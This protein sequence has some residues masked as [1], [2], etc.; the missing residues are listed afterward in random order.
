M[1]RF[2][3]PVLHPREHSASSVCLRRECHWSLP[4]GHPRGS[5]QQS[6]TSNHLKVSC[7]SSCRSHRCGSGA[8]PCEQRTQPDQHPDCLPPVAE[9]LATFH[10]YCAARD[11][12]GRRIQTTLHVR[13]PLAKCCSRSCIRSETNR[14]PPL[15]DEPSPLP[16]TL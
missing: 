11:V 14:R 15:G 9:P 8:S 13:L 16:L 2:G 5:G 7:G 3:Y 6:Q 4:P 10:T 12:A 1:T